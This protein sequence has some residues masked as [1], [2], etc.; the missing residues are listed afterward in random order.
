MTEER[1]VAIGD[2][3]IFTDSVGRDHNA[4]CTNFFG[5]KCINVAHASADVARTDTYGRQLER[6]TSVLHQSGAP[7]HGNFWRH[8][9]E[10][11]KEVS[12]PSGAHAAA[13]A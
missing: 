9:D 6:S 2:A 10:A 7:P 5:P 11:K 3:V 12:E 4:V 8:A 13:Q 1:T